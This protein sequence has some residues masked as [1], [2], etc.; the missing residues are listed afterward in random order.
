MGFNTYTYFFSAWDTGPTTDPAA[1]TSNFGAWLFQDFD[2]FSRSLRFTNLNDGKVYPIPLGVEEGTWYEL[3]GTAIGVSGSAFI[4][5]IDEQT[6]HASGLPGTAAK[7]IKTGEQPTAIILPQGLTTSDV[8]VYDG[9]RVSAVT[10]EDDDSAADVARAALE[11]YATDAISVGNRRVEIY[12]DWFSTVAHGL[13]TTQVSAGTAGIISAGID[14]TN[15]PGVMNYRTGTSSTGGVTV[16]TSANE[17]ALGQGRVVFETAVYVPT[18][19]VLAQRF[20]F[21]T[22]FLDEAISTA[23]TD[24]TDGVYFLYDEGGVSAGSAASANW[25]CVT[26]SNASRTVTGSGIAVSAATWQKLGIEINAAGTSVIFR[27]NGSTVATVATTIPTGTARA[28]GMGTRIVKSAG[29]TSRSVN[30][31]YIGFSMDL[32]TSR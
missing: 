23:A 13:S 31:D 14:T 29:T 21:M 32:T 19:S 3:I 8:A 7:L 16:S 25:Q 4:P 17:I 28:V 26:V 30:Q 2:L 27:I 18:L 11:F 12:T 5:I 6:N 10:T 22:G 1:D 24:Q 20:Q 9:I 15:R